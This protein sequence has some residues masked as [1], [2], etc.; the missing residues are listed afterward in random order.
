MRKIY[1]VALILTFF[2]GIYCLCYSFIYEKSGLIFFIPANIISTFIC[3]GL[4]LLFRRR[5]KDN[6][7][8]ITNKLLIKHGIVFIGTY[9]LYRAIFTICFYVGMIILFGLGG[10]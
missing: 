8:K 5:L 3:L 2:Y 10:G 6:A 4:L 1:N 9:F 7:E